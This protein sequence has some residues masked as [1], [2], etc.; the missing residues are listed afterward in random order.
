MTEQTDH[1]S[2][3]LTSAGLAESCK[4]AF[5]RREFYFL[6]PL[7]IPTEYTL[8]FYHVGEVTST[9]TKALTLP[10][11]GVKEIKVIY[12]DSQSDG[13]GQGSN[14]WESEK[15][16]NLTFSIICRADFLK[17]ADRFLLLQAGALAVR[18]VVGKL[19]RGVSIKWPNDIYIGDRKVS[20]TLTEL[21]ITSGRIRRAVIGIG[22][23]VNQSRFLSDAPNPVSILN[24]TG[25]ETPLKPLLR[26]LT[27]RFA[28]EYDCLRDNRDYIRSRYFQ[29]LWRLEGSH[30]Y[31]DRDGLFHAVIV[32]VE[33][34]GRLVL[35]DTQGRERI[36]SFREVEAVPDDS[37]K[38]N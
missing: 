19:I 37:V 20:G 23:N 30:L 33:N 36:Y 32:R 22:L 11:P 34:D 38:T 31:R 29:H 5:K 15:G 25:R 18:H 2:P 7:K 16:K 12:A 1:K 17:P 8:S 21:D 27:E 28:M 6:F 24:A 4:F 3:L 9:N 35:R 13:R 26:S 14:H 10:S